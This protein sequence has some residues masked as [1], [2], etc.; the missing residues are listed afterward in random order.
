MFGWFKAIV[1]LAA[2][3]GTILLLL[4]LVAFDVWQVPSDDPLLTA[5]IQP[6]LSAGD[7][8]V[9]TRRPAVARGNLLRCA[10]PEAPGRFVIGRAMAESGERVSVD[11]DVVSVDG[12]RLPSPRA[13]EERT[14]TVV[15]PTT[16]EEVELF[17]SI[18][19]Y[20]ESTFGAL[21][22]P[23]RPRPSTTATV[24]R[25]KW[26]LVSDDR[27]VHLDSRDYGQL[28][29]AG[30]QHIVLRIVGPKG[31]SDARSR[32]TVLW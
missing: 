19:D 14:R 22:Q 12:R 26:F 9:V 30:C 8:I 25:G 13:C 6:T 7:W 21:R 3:I 16:N 2:F 31:L 20:G 5:S 28:D 18:E 17:C 10:D 24:D 15:D 32:L 29:P 11:N 23:A 27:H 1:W 4:Y